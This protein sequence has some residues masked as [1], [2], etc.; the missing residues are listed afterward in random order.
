MAEA[1]IP[2]AETRKPMGRLKRWLLQGQIKEIEGP[3][4]PPGRHRKH[5]WWQV[6]CLTG[7]DYFSTLGYQPGIA[8]VAAGA[9]S[10]IATLILVLITLFGALP[11]YKRVAEASPHGDGSISML[12]NL[13]S[14]WKGKLFV[15][16][17]LGF[18]ATG[19]IITI[20]LSAADA[21][22]H[23]IEN[24]YVHH[25]FDAQGWNVESKAWHV[26]ITLALLAFLGA[27]FLKGFK[28]AIGIAVLI[29]IAYMF[30]NLITIGYS[31]YQ[32]FLNPQKIVDWKD[33]LLTAQAG[34]FS[35]GGNPLMI[36]GIALFLFP[37]L[38]LGLSGFE[39]G[40]VV[41][42]LVEGDPGDTEK[43]PEGRIRNTKK[44]LTVAALIMSVMLITSSFATITLIPPDEF[45]PAT[46]T[47]DA[48]KAAGRALAYLA[49]TYLG[50]IFGTVYDVST[51]L[52]LW[53]AGASALAGLLNI[54]PRYLPRYGM[55]PDWAKATRPLVLIFTAI[56]FLVTILF[57]AEVEAQA[58]AYATGV[59]VLM[60]SA[61]V[62]VTLL[63]WH[64][65]GLTRWA[66]LLVSLVFGYTTVVNIIEQPS[67]IKIA[68]LFIAGIVTASLV[69]RVWRTT[70]LRVEHIE[71]DD[72]ARRF[73]ED[74]GRGGAVRIVANRRDRGDAAEYDAKEREKRQDNHIPTRDPV[75]F[76]E[77]TPGDASEFAGEL[78][79]HGVNIEGF[80]VLR[81][82][83]PAVP[84]AIA[85]FLLY[86]RDTTGKIPHV[87]FGWSEGNPL[88]YLLRYI[89]FGEGDTA[90]VTREIL[91]QVE[92]DPE[93]R[94]SVHVGG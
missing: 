69:S 11:M 94:P 80:R 58:G 31:L 61:A 9:I 88:M 14:R 83:S 74:V 91:R 62:A 65:P 41:M 68:S 12:E 20:T 49:H 52:I 6:M 89:A 2:R 15:L 35:V 54:V 77:V 25:L 66:F 84:N 82:R 46:E 70:E 63:V 7:V 42:P 10:P 19:F 23:I 93:R 34:G 71:L 45:R 47:Q 27:V 55:A 53:F 75:V 30:L 17:L 13:L 87:Y 92:E 67:G 22:A 72:M 43:K 59:L 29:V 28:E 81:T 51:I 60:G 26:G 78:K 73:V 57:R 85:A 48:G 33:S 76:F 44:L 90:P 56:A 1:V 24:P 39:T 16:A 5:P 86:L 38:A 50:D 21:T 8:A 36:A 79:V 4:E 64:K 37:K 3:H 18:A 32:I 40:V